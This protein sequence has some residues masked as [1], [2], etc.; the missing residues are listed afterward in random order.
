MTGDGFTDG[1]LTDLYE[2]TMAAGYFTAGISEEPATFELSIRRLPP[3]RGYVVAAGLAQA[4]EYLASVSFSKDDISYLRSLEQFRRA[5]EGFF[6]R[7]R[8]FRFTGDL[9]A[10]PEGTPVFPGEPLL[11]VRAPLV[12]A[13]IPDTMAARGLTK[14]QVIHDVLLD[15]QP[16]KQFVT[17]DQV[18][19]LATFLSSD[20]AS[21][22]NGAILPIDGGWTAH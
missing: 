9:A 6:D 15:A 13:Q 7:L 12:E 11:R 21:S 19:E 3:G 8:R 1:L 5:P 17:I 2:L 14:E 18:A 10:V 16:T 22:I 20:A 4:V